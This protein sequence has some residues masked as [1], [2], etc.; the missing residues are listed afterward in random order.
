MSLLERLRRGL[1]K[2]RRLFRQVLTAQDTTELEE[3]LLA[4]D[5]G[6]K[7]TGILVEK[8][9][10]S[11]D[12]REVLEAEITRL[13]SVAS[14]TP[15]SRQRPLVV[16]LVGVNGSGKTTTAGKLCRYY[17]GQG[18]RVVVA[19]ADTY[20]DAAAEQLRIWATRADVEIVLSQQGQ[21]AAAVAFDA[22]QRATQRRAD[23]VLVDTAGRLHTR[24]DLMDEVV[25]IRRVSGK[26]RPGAP[27]EVWLVLDAT[28]GQNG[29]RQAQVFHQALG[30]TGLIVTKLD[31]TARGGV[32]IPIVMELGVP[33]RFVGIGEEAEDLEEFDPREFARGLFAD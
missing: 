5:V 31:G 20:R 27:D 10:R 19:A 26:V 25:K 13:L 8:V 12:R 11:A 1:D 4:A 33:I 17:S 3:L 21:D 28:V 16:M 15:I 9:K 22:I 7:A 23:V 2:T 18:R 6:V 14:G 24:K 32:L 30:L 29:I